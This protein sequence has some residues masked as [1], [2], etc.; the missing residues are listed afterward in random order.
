MSRAISIQSMHVAGKPAAGTTKGTLQMR[1]G[2]VALLMTVG[3]I[4]SAAAGSVFAPT[5]GPSCPGTSKP[6]FNVWRCPGPYG[7]VAEF[8]DEGNIVSFAIAKAPLRG[9]MLT[10]TATFRGSGKV[11]GDKLEWIVDNGRPTAA[12]LRT[13]RVD[14][15]DDGTEKEIQEL[16]VFKVE[17]NKTCQ[18]AAVNAR[19]SMANE[20]AAK[21]AADAAK[22]HCTEK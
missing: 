8:S 10:P 5:S 7:Y 21:Q 14:T 22:G 18:F 6:E 16:V 11:F 17:P 2:F 19:Q 3:T 15:S 12:I 20:L 9:R 13:W 4:T 1:S